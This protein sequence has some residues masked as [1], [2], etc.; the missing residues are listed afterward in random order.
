MNEKYTLVQHSG[1]GYGHKPAFKQGLEVRSVTLKSDL[2]KIVKVGGIVFDTWQ[3]ASDAE[4]RLSYP[5]GYE[6][7]L[8]IF[9][10]TFSDHEIDGLRIAIPLRVVVS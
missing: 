2:N 5:E 7:M 1:Y 6:G 9:R 3:E 10:G 8:P 4:E